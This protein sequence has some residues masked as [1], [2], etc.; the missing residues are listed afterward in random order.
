MPR[1]LRRSVNSELR[2]VVTE[3]PIVGA[4]RIFDRAAELVHI[5]ASRDEADDWLRQHG[6]PNAVLDEV[7]ADHAAEVVG[8]AAA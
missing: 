7:M 8:R 4:V 3:R 2:F 1:T 5:A 6:Y